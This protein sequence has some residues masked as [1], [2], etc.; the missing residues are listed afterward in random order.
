MT[1]DDKPDISLYTDAQLL[2]VLAR[3]LAPKYYMEKVGQLWIQ[4]APW[5]MRRVMDTELLAVCR[6]AE[7]QLTDEQWDRYIESD[8]VYSLKS[9]AHASWQERTVRLANV[10]GIIV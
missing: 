1:M 5:H 10:H 6:E 2:P 7:A 3:L 4:I 9:V 8:E